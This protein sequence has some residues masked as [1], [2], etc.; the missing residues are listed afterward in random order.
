MADVKDFIDPKLIQSL[1]KINDLII[2]SGESIEKKLIPAIEKLEK[3][4][5]ELG[6]TTK[7]EEEKRDQLNK[8]QQEAKKIATQLET[9]EAKISNARTEQNKELLKRKQ[10]LSDINRQIKEDIKLSKTQE[11]SITRLEARNKELRKTIKSLDITQSEN[12]ETIKAYNQEIDENNDKIKENSDQFLKAKQ[13]IGNYEESIKAALDGTDAF[14]GGTTNVINNF[15]QLSQQE[16]GVKG[17]FSTYT[18]GMKSATKAGLKFIATPIGA[19]IFAIVAAIGLFTGAIKRNQGASDQFSKIWSGITNVI[20]EVIGRV[21]KLAG[22]IGKL[23]TL[24]FKGF[25]KD[26]K[27]AFTGF[28]S[29]MQFAF[30]E[31]QKLRQLQI[32]LEE[33]TIKSTEA[34]ARFNAEAEKQQIIADDTTRSFKEREEAAELAREAG[35]RAANE[36]LILASQELEI[37]N[38]RVKQAK[39]QG[40]INRELRQEQADALVAFIEAEGTLTSVTL[41]NE[42]LRSEL[43]QDRL[44]RD[45]DILID[46]FDNVKTINERIIADDKQTFVARQSLLSQTAE[47]AKQS[48][49][50]QVETIQ[51]F[52]DAQLNANDL[53]A[54][55]DAVRLNQ[56]IRE[57]ELSEI[58]EGRLLEIIRERRIAVQDLNDAQKDL[59]GGLVEIQEAT[60]DF[61]EADAEL[62]RIAAEEQKERDQENTEAFFEAEKQK[63]E[64]T[65]AEEQARNDIRI[66]GLE[67]AQNV[68]Q[69]GINLAKEGS[70]LQKGLLIGQALA[71]KANAIFK[72]KNATNLAVAQALAL[73]LP[74]PLP[75]IVAGIYKGLGIAQ[76]I[77]VATRPIPQF[78]KGTNFAPGGAAIVGEKGRELIQS[79]RGEVYLAENPALINLERGSKVISN[80]KTEAILNDRNIVKELRNTR[81]A[82]A[83]TR[84]PSRFDERQRGFREG[85]LASKHRMN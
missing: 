82:I 7:D 68:I 20:E 14:S 15:I 73:P 26:A 32:D 18:G 29:A 34:T 48:F 28:G 23:M 64:A 9:T 4:Q 36:G 30:Q 71:D 43:R 61:A 63:T 45:L 37:V 13:N 52:T 21:F 2:E 38:E 66:F 46:G 22:A 6:K 56:K 60:I 58:I 81:R 75:Q 83:S 49:D 39:R 51:Q 59:F 3:S 33:A 1:E 55:Q 85:Y 69:T 72:I 65:A 57:L 70:E 31:G 11:N 42:K 17:F 50:K 19:V 8:T 12:I 77:N 5:A 53:L 24:D 79:P 44:E 16:G 84:R 27:D 54:E 78:A 41:E 67:A 76:A 10:Q 62:D 25:G 80:P 47:L 74:P 35:A 40:K